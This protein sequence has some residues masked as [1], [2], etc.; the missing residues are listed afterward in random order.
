MKV[1][2]LS[3][4]ES[5]LKEILRS[6]L[7]NK[8]VFFIGAG[9]SKFSETELIKLP[10]WNELISELKEELNLP[11]EN[12]YLKV[13][14]L[15][16]L[17]FGQHSY[18]QRIQASIKD[19]DPSFMHRNLFNLNPRYIITTNWDTLIE[20]TAIELGLAYD[21]VSSDS[22]LAQSQL[23]KKI[24]KMHGDFKQHNFVFKEDDYLQY[25]QNFPLI[26]NYIKGIF[27]TCTIIFLGYSYNDYNL[28]QIVSWIANISKATPKKYLLQKIFDETQAHYLKGHGI[29]L[30]APLVGELS[31]KDLY[32]DFFQDLATVHN[33]DELIKKV[34]AFAETELIKI[35]EDLSASLVDKNSKK[36][37]LNDFLAKKISKVID[38]KISP[39]SQYKVILPEQICRKLTNCTIEYNYHDGVN[40]K[41]HDTLLTNDFNEHNRKINAIYIDGILSFGGEYFK[42]FSSVLKKSFI[43]K[44]CY[45]S[46]YYNIEDVTGDVNTDLVKKLTFEYSNDSIELLF[47]NKS[48][49]EI[50]ESLL[51]KVSLFLNDKNYIMAT[52]YMYNYDYIYGL[53][54]KHASNKHDSLYEVSNAI[55]SSFSL[56]DYKKKILDFPRGLQQDLQDLVQILDMKDIY[57]AYYRFNIESEKNLSLA[58]TRRNGGFAFS[59]DEYSI[60]LKLY[61]YLYFIIGNNLIIDNFREIKDFF[62]KNIVSSLE[63]YLIENTFN[64]NTLD[65]FIIIKY[66][67]TKV[68]KDFSEELIRDKKFLAVSKFKPSEVALIKKYLLNVMKNLVKVFEFERK[69]IVHETSIGRWINNLLVTL[70][71]VKWYPRELKFIINNI[72]VL[73]K[74]RAGGFVIYE[75]FKYFLNVNFHLYHRSHSDVLNVLD[76]ILD[77]IINNQLNGYDMRVINMNM[78]ECIF[79]ISYNHNHLYQNSMLLKLALHRIEDEHIEVKKSITKNILLNLRGIGSPDIKEL[80]DDFVLKNI[81]PLAFLT[82]SDFIDNL[83][84]IAND[85]PI[86]TGFILSLNDF[87]DANIPANLSTIEMI[88]AGIESRLPEIL[89]YII[90]NKKNTDFIPPLEKFKFKMKGCP[91]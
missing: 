56:F 70:G 23:D 1:N 41:F 27:S 20:K 30:L 48:Y 50:L 31:Y 89:S 16:Y 19:L 47:N 14:Q 25:N 75:N 34:L 67:G 35:D 68:I 15:Y 6:S 82:P 59:D 86:P 90:D 49:K 58:Q 81:Y 9:F 18:V 45:N 8:L 21:L 52:I 40:L 79:E 71:F 43:S 62:E 5:D 51:V 10:D 22:D 77:K 83:I 38:E 44:V 36:K 26:E 85:Y 39:L 2:Y 76:V 72:V 12:D 91:N 33:P 54:K 46:K 24:I 42:S 55:I 65:I 78:L 7:A 84:L 3:F 17:K 74:G 64:V 37:K 87:I 57:R 66:C 60:R 80:V 61:P 73:L 69:D 13:A 4:P 53:V 29:S 32:A 28:K 11:N 63:H 88:K